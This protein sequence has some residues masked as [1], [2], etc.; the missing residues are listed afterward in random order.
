VVVVLVLGPRNHQGR[1]FQISSI[2]TSVKE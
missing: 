1:Q 2:T